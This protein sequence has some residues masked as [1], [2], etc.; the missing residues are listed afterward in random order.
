[1]S[2]QHNNIRTKTFC[3]QQYTTLLT[4]PSTVFPDMRRTLTHFLFTTSS[5]STMPL[6][7]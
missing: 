5:F 1:M 7:R 6:A 4:E 3:Q 2:K